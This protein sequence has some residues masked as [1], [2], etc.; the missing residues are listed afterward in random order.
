MTGAAGWPGDDAL[1]LLLARR[2]GVRPQHH[3]PGQQHMDK[4]ATALHRLGRRDVRAVRWT[5]APTGGDAAD[6]A[7]SA[8]ELRAL[9]AA[10]EPWQPVAEGGDGPAPVL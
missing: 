3:A 1:R 6:F 8:D 5:S 2:I 7:G 9:L 10:A 4:V